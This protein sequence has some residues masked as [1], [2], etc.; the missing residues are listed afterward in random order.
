MLLNPKPAGQHANAATGQPLNSNPYHRGSHGD[1][2]LVVGFERSRDLPA[3]D[4]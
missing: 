1:A 3:N 2:F 4:R